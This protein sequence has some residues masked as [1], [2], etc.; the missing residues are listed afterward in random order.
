M[1]EVKP[2]I[3]RSTFALRVGK[4]ERLRYLERVPEAK[5]TKRVRG[6]P[7]TLMMM[8]LVFRMRERCAKLEKTLVAHKSGTL[9]DE[10]M[11]AEQVND[12]VKDL[13]SLIG[14][15]GVIFGESVAGD[16]ILP[17]VIDDMRHLNSSFGSFLL[18]DR[19]LAASLHNERMATVSLKDLFEDFRYAFGTEM[20]EALPGYTR[21]LRGVSGRTA[22][23]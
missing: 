19:A 6:R 3:S 7:M 8:R 21:K 4:L 2:F 13:F 20:D 14:L 18:Q 9:D 10:R 16:L 23:P 17:M 12:E 15:Y 11:F 1:A 22:G 5:Q